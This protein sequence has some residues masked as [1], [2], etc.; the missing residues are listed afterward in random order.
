MRQRCLVEAIDARAATV[1]VLRVGPRRSIRARRPR[2]VAEACR[3]GASTTLASD[4]GTRGATDRSDGAAF[5][6]C[7]TI[8]ADALSFS[9]GSRPLNA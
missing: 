3:A 4:G 1:S 6:T 7:A 9:N 2:A 8:T 5:V